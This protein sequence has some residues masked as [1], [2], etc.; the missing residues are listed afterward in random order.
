METIQYIKNGKGI[1]T[2]LLVDL[3]KI[4]KKSQ[5]LIEDIED[6]I[7][8]ELRKNSKKIDFNSFVSKVKNTN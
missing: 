2:G 4:N 6:I 5:D 3:S 7:S 1:T 8:Y